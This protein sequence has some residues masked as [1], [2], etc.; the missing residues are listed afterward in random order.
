MIL[1]SDKNTKKEGLNYGVFAKKSGYNEKKNKGAF[2]DL[3]NVQEGF[4]SYTIR[5]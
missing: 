2:G 4:K 3:Q 1:S 5:P